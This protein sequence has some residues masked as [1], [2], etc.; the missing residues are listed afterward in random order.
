MEALHAATIVCRD[1]GTEYFEVSDS[2]E[3]YLAVNGI[4]HRL[5]KTKR[6][7]TMASV[8]FHK[9]LPLSNPAMYDTYF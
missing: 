5:T 4:E 9:T 8:R 2:H 3:L 6:P 7:Q 1:P